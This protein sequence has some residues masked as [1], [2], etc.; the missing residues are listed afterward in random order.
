MSSVALIYFSGP[1]N[2]LESYC[3]GEVNCKGINVGAL[4]RNISEPNL[5]AWGI[6]LALSLLRGNA[7]IHEI[8]LSFGKPILHVGVRITLQ[9]G[10]SVSMEAT[11]SELFCLPF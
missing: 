2:D 7:S 6:E 3:L 10:N 8:S 1:S 11:L 5:R 4:L 9:T